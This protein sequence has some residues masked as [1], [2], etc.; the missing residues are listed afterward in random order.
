MKN[1]QISKFSLKNLIDKLVSSNTSSDAS[2]R[3]PR[4]TTSAYQ[5]MLHVQTKSTENLFDTYR[6]SI[7]D[8]PQ[9]LDP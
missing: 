6:K 9:M 2:P 7:I 8:H 4:R 1:S 3:S 5:R